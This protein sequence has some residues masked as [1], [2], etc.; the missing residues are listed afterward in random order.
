MLRQARSLS[1]IRKIS[2]LREK[3][4]Q[5]AKQKNGEGA[6]GTEQAKAE[7]IGGKK[8]SEGSVFS[9]YEVMSIL[10]GAENSGV[11]LCRL[12]QKKEKS[13]NSSRI[14]KKIVGGGGGGSSGGG[15]GG[16]GG[17]GSGG[18]THNSLQSNEGSG[19][20]LFVMKVLRINTVDPAQKAAAQ[21]FFDTM[22]KVMEINHPHMVKVR[23]SKSASANLK[24][25]HESS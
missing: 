5:R 13:S 20:Q 11:Y 24:D 7:V 25:A 12:K 16:G 3:A 18:N 14:L 23:E 15:G 2:G 9:K 4:S 17:G 6:E 8:R 1:P 22:D 19:D 10:G 21:E